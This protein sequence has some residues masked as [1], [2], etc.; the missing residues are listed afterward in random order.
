M[1]ILSLFFLSMTLLPSLRAENALTPKQWTVD[2]VTRDAL[3]SIPASATTQPA[4]VLFVFHGHGGTPQNMISGKY[5][6]L[7]PEA[8]VV[9]PE[10]LKTTIPFYDP[11]GL[12][13]GWQ[14][15]PG[16]NDDRDLKFFDTMLAGLRK[17]CRVDDKRIYVTGHSNGGGFAYALWAERGP[18]LAAVAPSA[19]AALLVMQQLTP[20]PA[21]IVG[22]TNDQIVKFP[23]QQTSIDAVLKLNQCGAGQPAGPNT[24]IYPSQ[25]GNPFVTYIYPGGHTPPPEVTPMI[26]KFFRDGV[27]GLTPPPASQNQ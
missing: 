15:G 4:P 25:N 17:D 23:L 26:V 11:Q 27:A 5:H 6:K 10:G 21:F 16:F 22:G 2:G 3:V 20:K 7:W 19:S 9:Y 24:T 12:K 8:I 14:A 18:V 1:R 13:T